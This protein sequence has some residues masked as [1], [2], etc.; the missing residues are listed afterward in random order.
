MCMAY[1]SRVGVPTDV[2]NNN[3]VA[4]RGPPRYRSLFRIRAVGR[5]TEKSSTAIGEVCFYLAISR[6]D[7]N[8]TQLIPL[9][10]G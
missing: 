1:D 7:V 3:P 5:L 10:I 9:S 8:Q 2:K 6:A 4:F